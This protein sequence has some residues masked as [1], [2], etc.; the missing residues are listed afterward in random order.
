M[1][2]SRRLALA[3]MAAATSI[4]LTAG[5]G[6]A[7]ECTNLD[8]KAGAGAQLVFGP[9]GE[10]ITYMSKGLQ[11]RINQ[12]LVDLETGE[13]FSGI[14]AF[15]EDGDGVA[16]GFT[17]IVTPDGEIPLQA[18]WRGSTCHGVIN[19]DAMLTSCAPS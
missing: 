1:R 8:K 4:M 3:G 6:M 11:N 16:D 19:F 14:I 12:G 5:A 13:G 9:E 15:D 2:M 7:H 17:W 18:Q 10:G